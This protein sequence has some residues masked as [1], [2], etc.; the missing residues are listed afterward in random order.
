MGKVSDHVHHISGGHHVA[1]KIA[2]DVEEGKT[3]DEILHKY[4]KTPAQ[5]HEIFYYKT[6]IEKDLKAGIPLKQVLDKH[7][8]DE[9]LKAEIHKRVAHHKS[10]NIKK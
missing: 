7:F 4:A 5:K 9:D 10:L 6:Q 8:K 2:K 1:A 3:F